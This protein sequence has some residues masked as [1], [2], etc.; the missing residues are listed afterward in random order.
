MKTIIQRKNSIFNWLLSISVLVAFV[1]GLAIPA[2][3]VQAASPKAQVVHHR[4][5]GYGESGGGSAG[6][7]KGLRTCNPASSTSTP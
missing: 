7:G 4:V 5:Q 1:F 2:G 6:P 3:M